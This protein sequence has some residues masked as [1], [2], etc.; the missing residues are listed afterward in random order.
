MTTV[1]VTRP[2]KGKQFRAG[3]VYTLQDGVA[4]WL[5]RERRAVL[6]DHIGVEANAVGQA[7]KTDLGSNSGGDDR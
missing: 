1:K 6:C 2:D 3:C 7:V 4:A 5:I